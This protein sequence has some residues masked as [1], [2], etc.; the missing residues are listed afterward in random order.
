MTD[1]APQSPASRESAAETEAALVLRERG[2]DGIVR[3]VLNR[4]RQRNALSSSLM[5]ALQREIDAVREDPAVRVVVLAANGPVFSSGHDLKEMRANV[6]RNVCRGLFSQ[7]SRLMISIVQL[8][9]PV[10]AEVQGVATA[11]GCQLVASCDLALAAHSAWFAT[12]GVNIGLFCSTPAVALSRSVAHK[13]AME[14]LLT[15]ER[16]SAARAAEIGLINR[17]VDDE[18]LRSEVDALAARVAAASPLVVS[19]GKQAFYRQLEMDLE[20][21]YAFASEIMT[22]NM[23]AL[24]AREGIDA[25]LD[26][27]QPHWRGE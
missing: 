24:D 1:R 27:R 6:D 22:R 7:C 2:G 12:P 4:P 26:K 20:G 5:S 18:N 25:F 9:K 13:S 14:M 19:L 11:A 23:M 17:A 8:P 16:V 15:G 3:L 10:I 21:A